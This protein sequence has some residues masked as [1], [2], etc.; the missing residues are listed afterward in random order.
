MEKKAQEVLV[1]VNGLGYEV[2]VPMTTVFQLP[3]PG[4]E[5]ILHTHF[6]VRD[7]APLLYGFYEEPQRGL[8]R[9]LIRI[10]GVGP[11]LALTILSGIEVNDF[12]NSV[13][14]NDVN[15]LVRLPGVGKKT[16]ERL[17]MEVRDR[18]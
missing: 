13:N 9:I 16:A 17:V 5:V 15:A 14:N 12:V 3:E 8:F 7:D 2:Q 4:H 10:N 1:D 11:K 18:L 6:V